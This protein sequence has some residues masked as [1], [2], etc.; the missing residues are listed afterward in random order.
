MLVS[1]YIVSAVRDQG[2]DHCFIG[3]GGL[4]D[5]FMPPL[6][7]T[8]G[9]RTIVAAFEGGAAYMADGYARASGGLGVC[10]A[11]AGRGS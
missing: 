5:N 2:V 6:A 1:E 3:L 9:L 8:K 7:G 10:S 11:S 4:N